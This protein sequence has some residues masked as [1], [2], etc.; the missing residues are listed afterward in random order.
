[1][2]EKGFTLMEVLAVIVILAII[3]LITTPIILNIVT[4]AKEEA[5]K[6]SAAGYIESVEMAII[7]EKTKIGNND[8]DYEGEY[9]INGATITKNDTENAS[10]LTGIPILDTTTL[11][12]TVK[13][14]L[15]ETGTLTVNSKNVVSEA[16][17][18][19]KDYVVILDNGKYNV[20][21]LTSG[22]SSQNL[23]QIN[24]KIAT[25]ESDVSSLQSKVTSLEGEKSALKL[26]VTA[27]ENGS[28]NT[29]E[30]IYSGSTSGWV[31]YS[32]TKSI[33]NYKYLIVYSDSTRHNNNSSFTSAANTTLLIDVASVGY[34]TSTYTA[35]TY[36]NSSWFYYIHFKFVDKNTFNLM[37]S[38]CSGFSAPRIYKIVG[39]K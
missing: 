2:K 20:E 38:Y 15:P 16:S 1:M 32:L 13:G 25:L 21:V 22:G 34:N 24:D 37:E 5:K 18:N 3:A 10:L 8:I 23:T 29:Y 31:N 11:N 33:D 19:Y 4:K 35:I 12:V 7:K 36:L 6:S 26:Q 14:E 39:V 28:G 17:I 9:T 27:L 30:T